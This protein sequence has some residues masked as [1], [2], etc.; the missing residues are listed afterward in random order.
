MATPFLAVSTTLKWSSLSSLVAL[1]SSHL[2]LGLVGGS[3]SLVHGWILPIV[4][5]P[6]WEKPCASFF[7]GCYVSFFWAYLGTTTKFGPLGRRVSC[8]KVRGWNRLMT[9]LFLVGIVGAEAVVIVVIVVGPV[10]LAL[11]LQD[12]VLL[13][14]CLPK[15]LHPLKICVHW[16]CQNCGYTSIYSFYWVIYWICP[17][18]LT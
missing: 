15:T 12:V 16:K 7:Y 5:L 8:T 2:M 17:F 10:V 4:P 3:F 6:P 11:V 1:D 13:L 18:A 14:G 9:F